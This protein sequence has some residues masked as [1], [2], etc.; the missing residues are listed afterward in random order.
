VAA[1]QKADELDPETAGVREQVEYFHAEPDGKSVQVWN[2]LG[3]LFFKAADYNEAARA[4]EKAIKMDAANGWNYSSLALTLVFQGRYKDAIPLYLRSIDL[5]K[6]DKEKAV[7]WN[8]LGNVYR[9]LN[10]Y[11]SAIEAYQN[12]VK[13]NDEKMTLLTRTRFSLL[14]NCYID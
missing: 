6:D 10:D 3:D 2:E 12:A 8:R 13:L 1:Y 7:S 14:G 4:Y 11:D 5:L 9:R